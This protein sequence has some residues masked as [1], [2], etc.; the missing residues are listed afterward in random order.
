MSNYIH[1]LSLNCQGIRQF[2]K[3]A[4]LKQYILSQ[5]CHILLLSET[6]ITVDIEKL[7]EKEFNEWQIF[8]SFGSSNSRGCSILINKSIHFD[9]IDT[10]KDTHGRYLL[11]NIAIDNNVFT[12]LNIYAHNELSKRNNFFNDL[13]K[14]L[15]E[16]AQGYIIVGGDMNDIIQ[17]S[18]RFNAKNNIKSN[19]G[20]GFANFIKS[21]NLTDVW[22]LFNENKTQYTWRRKNSAEKSRIDFWLVE[23]NAV[24]LVVKSDIR[25]ACIKYTDHQAISLKLQKSSKRGNGYWKMNISYL[26]ESNYKLL[27]EDTIKQCEHAYKNKV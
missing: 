3:R 12:I 22:K 23:D 16:N 14:T 1:F 4:R 26:K 27:I 6:H 18:D 20:K 24:P 15:N 8:H 19:P 25:P 17:S 11:L 5:K 10:L 21:N 2:E 9:I 7:F 13:S